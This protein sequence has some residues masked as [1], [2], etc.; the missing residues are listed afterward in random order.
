MLIRLK[1]SIV[2]DASVVDDVPGQ[3]VS[4]DFAGFEI[5]LPA[6]WFDD[7]DTSGMVGLADVMVVAGVLDAVLLVVEGIGLAPIFLSV[8]GSQ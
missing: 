3:F 6:G 8:F 1:C 2:W 7:V 5:E 4:M